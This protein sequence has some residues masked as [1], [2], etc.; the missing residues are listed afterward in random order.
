MARSGRALL[1]VLASLVG[2]ALLG[3]C[4]AALSAWVWGVV[5]GAA[6]AAATAV[7]LTPGWRSRLPFCLGWAVVVLRL[8][9]QRAEGDYLVGGDLPGYL[10][11]GFSLVLAVGGL[12][13][14]A[15]R[16]GTRDEGARGFLG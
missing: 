16:R 1:G 13:G 2:G 11:L 6:A 7:V 8:S 10:L 4:A 15:P 9:V 3:L 14:A 5:L 12:I